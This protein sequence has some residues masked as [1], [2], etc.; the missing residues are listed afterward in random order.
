[1]CRSTG[2]VIQYHAN[3]TSD[4]ALAAASHTAVRARSWRTSTTA[5]TNSASSSVAQA[6]RC[7]RNVAVITTASQQSVLRES[8]RA[9]SPIPRKASGSAKR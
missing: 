5:R 6:S 3:S 8:D 2:A 9:A 4:G 1:M 7:A